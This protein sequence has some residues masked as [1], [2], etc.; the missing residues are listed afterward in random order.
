MRSVVSHRSHRHASF[1]NI[2]SDYLQGQLFNVDAQKLTNV[3][4][5]VRAL[6][7]PLAAV[8][9]KLIPSHFGVNL[10]VITLGSGVVL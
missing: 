9:A 2:L 1:T 6:V 7:N 8:A 10:I 4:L 3:A 5:E